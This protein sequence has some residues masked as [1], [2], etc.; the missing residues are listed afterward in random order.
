MSSCPDYE[1]IL[2][3]NSNFGMRIYPELVEGHNNNKV[4]IIKVRGTSKVPRT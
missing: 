2:I 4:P 1:A 3:R